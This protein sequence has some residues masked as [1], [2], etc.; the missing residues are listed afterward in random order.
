MDGRLDG[1]HQSRRAPR[2][3]VWG[4]EVPSHPVVGVYLVRT[5]IIL[6]ALAT[7]GGH[8]YKY[9]SSHYRENV[10]VGNWV[11]ISEILAYRKSPLQYSFELW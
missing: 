11:Y 8:I 5:C 2:S 1:E 10:V 6:D 3:K 7:S 4:I 9:N